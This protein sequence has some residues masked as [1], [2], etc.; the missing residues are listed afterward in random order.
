MTASISTAF[1]DH[2]MDLV[3]DIIRVFPNDE[4]LI[5]AKNSFILIRKANPKMLVKI[6]KSYIVDKYRSLI[7]A[8]DISFFLEKDYTEDIL[9]KIDNSEKIIQTIDRLRNPIKMMNKEE[10]EKIMKY[11][12]NL[13]KLCIIFHS[14]V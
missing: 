11:I 12:Q 6:W 9:N 4:D 3:I 10:Q 7:E 13:T 14:T 2:L 8:G 1:N 5:T